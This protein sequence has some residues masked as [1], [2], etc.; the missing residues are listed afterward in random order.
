VAN[1][2]ANSVLL[3]SEKSVDTKKSAHNLIHMKFYK[4]KASNDKRHIRGFFE[5]QDMGLKTLC[6]KNILW[7][8]WQCV[9][10]CMIVDRDLTDIYNF[11]C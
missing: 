8:W 4:V 2:D 1:T 5:L 11:Q 10:S 6:D 3:C 9:V 7:V